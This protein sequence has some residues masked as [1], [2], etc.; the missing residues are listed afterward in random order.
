M[1]ETTINYAALAL[2]ELVPGCQW[3]ITDGT[4]INWENG[5]P[6][7]FIWHEETIPCPTKQEIEDA[8]EQVKQKIEAEKYRRQRYKEY[9]SI[10]DQLDALFKAGVFPEEMAAQIQA[11]KDKYPKGN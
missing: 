2:Q 3:T 9:P 7:N 4:S 11:I 1:I 8:I 6:T 10:G 5:S